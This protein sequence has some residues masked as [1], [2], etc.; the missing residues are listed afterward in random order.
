MKHKKQ[1]ETESKKKKNQTE[2][3]KQKKRIKKI[4]AMDPTPNK[5]TFFI[6]WCQLLLRDNSRTII[7]KLE[8][9]VN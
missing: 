3:Q 9:K 1:I 5:S 4:A 6:N 7:V 8:R 2:N